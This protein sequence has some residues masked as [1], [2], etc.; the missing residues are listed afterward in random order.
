MNDRINSEFL[1]CL[2]RW[3]DGIPGDLAAIEF[4]GWGWVALILNFLYISSP[5]KS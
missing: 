2:R 1:S 5:M 4:S 3:N